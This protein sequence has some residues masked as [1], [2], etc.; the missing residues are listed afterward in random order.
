ML[1]DLVPAFTSGTLRPLPRRSFALGDAVGAFRFMAQ[2]HHIGK[3]VL[4]MGVVRPD[5]SYLVTGGLGALGLQVARRLVD[6]GARHV[7]LVGRTDPSADAL[8]AVDQLRRIGAEILILRSDVSVAADVGRLVDDLSSRMPPLRGVVHLAG[9]LD[10]GVL[11][12]QTWP[13][14]AKVMAPKVD[15]AWHLHRSTAG[16]P[17][18]FFVLFSS[19]ASILG[20]TG[21][22]NYAAANAFLDA[23]A[24]HRRARQLPAVSVNWGPWAGAGMAGNVT[25]RDGRRRRDQGFEALAVG[26]GLDVFARLLTGTAPAQVA[27]SPVDWSKVLQQFAAGTAPPLLSEIAAA[28]P[29]GQAPPP[30]PRLRSLL[31][32]LEGVAP[33]KRE[34]AVRERIHREA[35]KVLGLE[36]GARVDATQPL[37]ELGLDSLMAVELRNTLSAALERTLPATLLFKYPTIEAIAG[38][39]LSELYEPA[40]AEPAEAA[41]DVD[42]AAIL[43]LSDDQ[44]RE[45]LAMELQS[46]GSSLDNRD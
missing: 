34:G 31:S 18:D 46:L 40:A 12:E 13:R 4:T 3:I 16:L 8:D 39:V 36:A 24:H 23:L 29:R 1:C 14:F 26:D 15:G 37:R 33:S 10:D 20:G 42:D 45:L 27:A 43:A 21:Q 28:V 22:G 32:E 5:A 38:F 11:S 44:T 17:L 9:V 35:A 2:A 30:A 6:L 19:L 41:A 7:A 25:E